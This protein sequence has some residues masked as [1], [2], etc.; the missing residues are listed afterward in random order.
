[1]HKR[2][3]ISSQTPQTDGQAKTGRDKGPAKPPSSVQRAKSLGEHPL[4]RVSDALAESMKKKP[5]R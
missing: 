4:T 5:A 2:G 3:D 1:M